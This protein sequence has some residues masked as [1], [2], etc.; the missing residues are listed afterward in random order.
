[1]E[2]RIKSV[3]RGSGRLSPSRRA[4]LAAL[5]ATLVRAGERL[6]QNHN[7][8]WAVSLGL[9]GH[10]KHVTFTDVLDVMQQTGF[11]GIRLTGYPGFL[12]SYDITPEFI[13]KD[14]TEDRGGDFWDRC[15][16]VG[17]WGP[18]KDLKWLGAGL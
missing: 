9:W 1:M 15:G 11:I 4:F 14:Y 10:F 18:G 13:Q 8:K 6:P 12:K 7:I 5:S 3:T 17:R 16:S 2:K